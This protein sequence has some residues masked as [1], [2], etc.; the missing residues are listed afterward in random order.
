MYSTLAPGVIS[1]LNTHYPSE[2]E[3]DNCPWL[4]ITG[5]EDWEPYNDSFTEH[6]ESYMDYSITPMTID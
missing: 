1:Y 2:T 5:N 4:V 3:V 6:E